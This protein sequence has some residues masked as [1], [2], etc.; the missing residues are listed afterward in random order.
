MCS[1]TCVCSGSPAA[2][3]P[4]VVTPGSLSV[5]QGLTARACVLED[6]VKTLL[7]VQQQYANQMQTLQRRI[8]HDEQSRKS[9]IDSMQV[10]LHNCIIY[11][12][13]SALACF[14]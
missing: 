3:C 6:V 8:L 1:L 9:D 2:A 12:I 7:S 5:L 4:P 14:S 10:L 11:R 13:V